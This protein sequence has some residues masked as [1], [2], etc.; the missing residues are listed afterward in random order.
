MSDTG[1]Q[2]HL[3]K[4]LDTPFC[5]LTKSK[6]SIHCLFL[7]AVKAVKHCGL[8]AGMALLCALLT[9][10]LL[11]AAAKG[12]HLMFD[13][14]SS[15][16]AERLPALAKDNT[17]IL[18]QVS[19]GYLEF[20]DNWA[21][22]MELLDIDNW[23]MVAEDIMALQYLSERQGPVLCSCRQHNHCLH[24]CV[25]STQGPGQVPHGFSQMTAI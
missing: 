23:L 19:C 11:S 13:Q 1:Q 2:P 4:T 21:I 12:R 7:V 15:R 8:R 5:S 18:T 25:C 9:F 22:H 20:A 24:S 17:V 16:L 6:H 14:P 3:R 10:V